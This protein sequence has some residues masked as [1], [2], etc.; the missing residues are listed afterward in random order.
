MATR[1]RPDSATAWRVA[2]IGVFAGSCLVILL[3]LWTSFGGSVPLKPRGYRIGAVFPDGTQLAQQ[4]DVR[5]SGVPVGRV[6]RVGSAGNRIRATLELDDRYV[7]L[8]GDV[9]AMLRAKTLLGETYVELTPGARGAAVIQE[10][11]TLPLGNV[12]PSIELDEIFR[13][14]DA[15]T[16]AGV[17]TWLQSQAA[18]VQ[19]RGSEV[20]DAIG[21]LPA[22]AQE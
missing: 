6:V 22:F 1:R 13:S 7:P 9:H 17:R 4:A 20:S 8:R 19:G 5:I 21:Q 11:S 3:L 16:R 18:S 2:A 12:R 14:F 15:R 10:G